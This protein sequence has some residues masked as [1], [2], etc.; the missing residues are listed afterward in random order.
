VWARQV[1]VSL[2]GRGLRVEAVEPGANL[3]AIARRRAPE[4]RV[5]VARFEEL[6]LPDAGFDAVFSATAFHWIDPGIAWAKA[7]RVLRPHG[8]LALLGYV[9]V[10]DDE[11]RT[12]QEALR[13][14]YQA[15]WQLRQEREVVEGALARADNISALW[16]WLEDPAIEI[17]QAGQLFGK[18]RFESTAHRLDLGAA[19]LVDLQRTTATHLSLDVDELERVERGMVELVEQLGGTFPIGQLAVLAVAE[20]R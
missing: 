17:A 10:T 1:D 16:A 18:A 9:N 20:R 4:A 5:H 13:D 7:A 3:A 8:I 15:R 2:V 19:E 6:A 12:S 14:L 11:T